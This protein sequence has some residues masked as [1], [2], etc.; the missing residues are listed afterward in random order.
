MNDSARKKLVKKFWFGVREHIL[1]NLLEFLQTFLHKFLQRFR[2]SRV[3][4]VLPVVLQT[5]FVHGLEVLE[6]FFLLLV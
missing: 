6:E 1:R 3:L 2:L 5:V 4:R